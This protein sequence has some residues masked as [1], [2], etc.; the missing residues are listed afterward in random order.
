MYPI[1]GSAPNHDTLQEVTG[2]AVLRE[3]AYPVVEF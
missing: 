2:V 1:G 3:S